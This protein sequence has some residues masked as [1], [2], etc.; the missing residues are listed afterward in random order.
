MNINGEI[1]KEAVLYFRIRMIFIIFT[2]LANCIC[3]V[4]RAYGIVRPTLIS[5]LIA[6]GIN[7]LVSLMVINSSFVSDKVAGV[8]FAAAIG[9]LL[10]F[11]YVFAELYGC[12]NVPCKGRFTPFILRR[13]LKVGIPAGMSLLT[14]V[15]TAAFSTAVIASLG[16]ATVNVKVFT[17]NISGFTYLFGYAVAQAGALMISRCVGSGRN[18]LADRL[19]KLNARFVPLLN[20]V[21]AFIVFVMTR[22]LMS[23]FTDNANYISE[24][25]IIF[26][27]DIIIET[28][29]GNTHVG[30]NALCSTADTLFAAIVTITSCIVFGAFGSWLMCIK[31][32]FG[33]YGYFIVS[34]IDEAV[35]GL[36]FRIRWKSGSWS[37][38]AQSIG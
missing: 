31:F 12:K 38:A 9:Q 14:Y 34:A 10:G 15:I 28:A 18:S 4:L 21:L 33:L 29:R 27:I 19:F 11:I 1:L 17:S 7:V 32:G 13:V 37:A 3:A 25:R 30:E 6:N 24:A 35:R 8:A 36:L 5:G 26:L 2:A 22:P 23:F 20:A 16:Q